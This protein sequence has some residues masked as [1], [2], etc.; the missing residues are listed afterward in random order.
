MR[1]ISPVK[2]RHFTGQ[3]Q[4]VNPKMMH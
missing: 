2:A 4:T 1:Y 3:R